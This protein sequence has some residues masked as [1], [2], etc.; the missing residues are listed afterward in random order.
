MRRLV[1]LC[2]IGGLSGILAACNAAPAPAESPAAQYKS[3][4]LDTFENKNNQWNEYTDDVLGAAGYTEKGQYRIKVL[5]TDTHLWA[6]PLNAQISS[7]GDVTVSVDARLADDGSNNLFG[8]MCRYINNESFYFFVIS[9]DGYY[10]IG[11]VIEGKYQLIN[12]NDYPPSSAIR[13]EYQDNHILAE[14]VGSQLRLYV[15]EQLV[16]QQTDTDLTLGSVGLIAGSLGGATV[17]DFDN[18]EVRGP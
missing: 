4:L 16:D 3:I 12:R 17:I 5:K 6:N 9:S 11:K 8:V 18:F 15:N 7:L 1:W 13:K 2:L 14:C 10:G